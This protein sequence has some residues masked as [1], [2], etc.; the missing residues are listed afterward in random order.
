MMYES[1]VNDIHCHKIMPHKYAN[2]MNNSIRKLLA[3]KTYAYNKRR[4]RILNRF[5]EFCFNER[6][7]IHRGS[8]LSFCFSLFQEAYFNGA[9]GSQP[10]TLNSDIRA[11]W[12]SLTKLCQRT[13]DGLPYT[14]SIIKPRVA[15]QELYSSTA[16]A[17][18]RLLGGFA[19]SQTQSNQSLTL[20]LE[21]DVDTF[22]SNLIDTMRKH[23]D[24]IY[25]VSKRYLYDAQK[26]FDFAK[27]ISNEIP[28][29]KFCDN[30]E[31]LHPEQRAKGSG[32]Y[33][34]LFSE[35]LSNGECGYSN[36]I[37]YIAH[38][39]SGLVNRNFI[40]GNNHLYRF[41]N[42]QYELRE[43][44][45]LSTLSAVAASNIIIIESGI[46]VDSLRQ[47]A[48]SAQGSM[49][50]FFEPSNHGFRIS[51][52]K[53]RAGAHIKRCIQ[54]I[55]DDPYIEVAF[56]YIVDTT[57]EQRKMMNCY[58]SSRLFIFHTATSTGKV[59]PMSSLPFRQGFKRL[60]K[61]ARELL[62]NDP[63]WCLDITPECID[64]VL[65]AQPNAKKLRATEGVIRWFDSGGNPAVAAKYLGNSESVSIRNYLPK[66]LQ[67]AVYSQRVRQFQNVLIASATNG[68]DYQMQ[69]LDLKDEAE[70]IDYLTRLEKRLP[71]WKTV[72]K[73]LSG[74]TSTSS[75]DIKIT[76]DI[77]PENIAL[78][79]ASFEIETA[80]VKNDESVEDCVAELSL[81]YL[82]L[83]NYLK[84]NPD[85]KIQ[86]IIRKGDSLYE[87]QANKFLPQKI[88]KI[89]VNQS[90]IQ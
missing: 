21:T 81:V 38:Y 74:N 6:L 26:R 49:N 32:Q 47:L 29:E 42:T 9:S 43:H 65:L 20:A 37:A 10:I 11:L 19:L 25:K 15:S 33:L 69:A 79:K 88:T 77:C 46:N 31:L 64:E 55:A 60:L 44:F 56:N 36:L 5:F 75:S 8:D 50:T 53:P 61:E 2:K 85:R 89:E 45:G 68:E 48:L 76:L 90:G 62:I 1:Y 18:S 12:G 16:N 70:L 34:S 86:R 63:N 84:A 23:R 87:K 17:S 7:I 27:Q 39:Q 52:H 73:T 22:I 14:P 35:Y 4:V 72:I 54:H 13:I 24:I 51:Y 67:L 3:G 83:K 80:R 59:I 71:H 66:E 41:T 40:G 58:D 82:S 30:P 57:E 28:K 78:M